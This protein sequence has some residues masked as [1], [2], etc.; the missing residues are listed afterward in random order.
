MPKLQQFL[1]IDRCPHCQIDKPSLK[2]VWST[3]TINANGGDERYWK[4]Y[5]CSR[6]GSLVIAFA[7]NDGGAIV[8]SYPQIQGVDEEV[9]ELAREYLTQA[10]QSAHA[11][12]G[13]VML[14]ASSVDTMLKAKGLAKSRLFD[15]IDEAVVTCP[16]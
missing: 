10:I 13:A 14:C 7:I 6:C 9:P 11:P 12:A 15:R 8:R 4:V 16:Q 5:T 2:T 1:D 3:S